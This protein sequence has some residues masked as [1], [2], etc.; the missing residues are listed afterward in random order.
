MV[1]QL[2]LAGFDAAPEPTDRLFFGIYP[3]ASAA[4]QIE[5]LARNLS[6]DHRLSGTPI[7]TER[8]HV[9]LYHINDYVGLPQGIVTTALQAAATVASTPFD[10]TFD[11]AASF[12]GRPG[13]LP[14]VLRSENGVATLKTFQTNLIKALQRV[15]L[16]RSTGVFIPHVTLLYD[17]RSVPVQPIAPVSW[18]A[19]EFVL[20][21]SELGKTRHNVLGRWPLNG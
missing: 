2:A 11:Y 6:E 18:T 14:F 17:A 13:Q 1:D 10:V 20:V 3:E 5:R 9:T 12:S 16:A 19:H 7:G 21:H 8:F 15:G 4:T